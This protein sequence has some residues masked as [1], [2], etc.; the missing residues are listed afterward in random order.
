MLGRVVKDHPMTRI[1]QKRRPR[2]AVRQNAVL[3]LLSQVT[4]HPRDFAATHCTSEADRWSIQV[5]DHHMPPRRL[6]IG[7]DHALHVRQ[8][9][10]LGPGRA[11][12]GAS[13]WPVATSRLRINVQV[14]WR[15]YSNSRRSTLPGASGSP[16][17]L[18]SSACTPVS[19]S[20]LT[21]RSPCGANVGASR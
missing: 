10:G 20:V 14:P 21:T 12:D 4:C 13:T 17:Y 15:I 19:S 11:A 16:G 6:G 2:L 7:R 5:V 18:R 1:T 9:V 8:K 3:A